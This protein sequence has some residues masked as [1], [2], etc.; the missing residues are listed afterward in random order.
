MLR[1]SGGGPPSILRGICFLNPWQQAQKRLFA[2]HLLT[3]VLSAQD[4]PSKP[5]RSQSGLAGEPAAAQQKNNGT[6][7]RI[8]KLV[9]EMKEASPGSVVVGQQ[10]NSES[11]S[12]AG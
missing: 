6:E 11:Q 9:N 12:K 10:L 5:A 3:P 8:T 2:V 1:S 7:Q 4:Q